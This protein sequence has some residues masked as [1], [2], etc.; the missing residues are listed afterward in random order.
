MLIISIIKFVLNIVYVWVGIL[1]NSCGQVVLQLV[2]F[3]FIFLSLLYMKVL[4]LGEYS[5]LHNSLKEGLIALGHEVLLVGTGDNFKKYPI[6]KD[7]S[8]N[9]HHHFLLNKWWLLIYKLTGY[10]RFKKDVYKNLLNILPELKGFDVI[11]LIN[12]DAFLIDPIDE[13]NFYK[14]LFQ[15]NKNVYLSACGEDHQVISFYQ[16]GGMRYSIL[17]PF[18][19]NPFL[20]NEFVFSFK[21]LKPSYQN[22]HN[23]II[24]HIR[25]LIPSDLDYAIPYKNHPKALP[26]IP[27]PI[28]TDLLTYIPLVKIGPIKIFFGINRLSYYKK[29]SHL[30]LKALEIINQKYSKK[31]E[32]TLA[33]NLPYHLY[34]KK[35]EQA[36]IL[37]DQAFSYD[38]GYN[39]LEAMA[40]GKCVL[41]GAEKEFEEFYRL[42]SPVA[43]NILPDVE[44]IVQKLSYL[45]EHP[46]VIHEISKNARRFIEEHHHYKQVAQHYIDIWLKNNV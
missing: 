43:V 40:Q 24:K 18:I 34:L 37:I 44:D 27:N 9:L 29:G 26:M 20:I 46:Y 15:H 7:V 6:D 19:D 32:I 23:F 5:R 21:Y 4:L 13:I 17:D 22:L 42:E 12:E 31:V 1:V 10:N 36:H 2:C 28:N 16:N 41:T 11:Q 33:E 38:Q 14:L 3:G 35:Y 25:G 45:I 30:I 39:A 8:S